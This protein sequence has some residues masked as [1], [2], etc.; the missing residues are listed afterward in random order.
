MDFE[1]ISFVGTTQTM[2]A[3]NGIKVIVSGGV[4]QSFFF[5]EAEALLNELEKAGVSVVR[6]RKWVTKRKP[7]TATLLDIGSFWMRV[8]HFLP[9][10]E[11][12]RRNGSCSIANPSWVAI[13]SC[14]D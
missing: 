13:A 10:R 14:L 4:E 2:D 12:P 1:N 9:A 3:G 11:S 6:L 5:E 8:A 7:D